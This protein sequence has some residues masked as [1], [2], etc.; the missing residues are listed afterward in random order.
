MTVSFTSLTQVVKIRIPVLPAHEGAFVTDNQTPVTS[1][2]LH[3]HFL[4]FLPYLDV[5]KYSIIESLF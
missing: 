3:L 2:V 4:C 1:Q 5:K